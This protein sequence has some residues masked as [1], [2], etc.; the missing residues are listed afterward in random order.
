MKQ[1][2]IHKSILK[3]TLPAVISNI[4]VPLLGLVD[5]TIV[6]H[7]GSSIYIG[8]V[9]L[10]TTIFNMVYWIFS[11][12]RMGTTGLVAQAHGQEDPQ[13]MNAVLRKALLAGTVI[14]ILLLIHQSQLLNMATM[15]MQPDPETAAQL[16]IYFYICIWGAPAV[17][18]QYCLNGWFIGAQD[19]RSPMFVALFQNI[20]NILISLVL[21]YALGWKM[22][23]VATGTMVA[24]W[25]GLGL[26]ILFMHKHRMTLN[27]PTLHESVPVLWKE[28]LAVNRDL[29]LRT[30]CLVCV[31][32]Y[33]VRAGSMQ[34]SDILAA[35]ALLMQL[36]IIYSYITDGLA[37]AGEALS[38]RYTGACDRHG[39]VQCVL[40]LFLWSVIITAIFTMAYI[41]AGEWI[42]RFFTDI[43]RV[44]FLANLFLPWVYMIPIVAM[45]AMVWDG[46][47]IGMTYTRGMLLSTMIG[48]IIFFAVYLSTRSFLHNDALWM[49][50]LCYLFAR[51]IVQ[52]LLATHKLRFL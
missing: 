37:N 4:S 34:G 14:S 50:F 3:L 21:V 41:F 12:L 35:N 5:S 51:G 40:A 27:A 18:G 38:G 15:I 30:L 8:T 49:A 17:L 28:F 11:F 24:Q 25:A 19:T 45:Q 23:G 29:F 31:T 43:P 33:F 6:G 26:C 48:A 1:E 20:V 42:I 44:L 39:L 32:V 2:N 10:G 46:V 52:T 36:F 47:F 13:R 22:E 16:R 7:M 9:A